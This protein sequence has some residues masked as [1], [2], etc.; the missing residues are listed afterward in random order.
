ML[1]DLIYCGTWKILLIIRGP[2]PMT[3]I[4]CFLLV[5]VELN[6]VSGRMLEAHVPARSTCF[7]F[8]FYFWKILLFINLVHFP[9]TFNPYLCNIFATTF[10]NKS[11]TYL[12]SH[13]LITSISRS[14]NKLVELY[15]G[16]T[17]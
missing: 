14:D 3:H 10:S 16:Q 2:I 15:D 4:L 13:V 6:G 17:L 12:L 5:D 8:Y 1:R 9:F 11:R 7:Y